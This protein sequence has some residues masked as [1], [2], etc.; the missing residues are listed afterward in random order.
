MNQ[1]IILIIQLLLLL[2][3]GGVIAHA[4]REIAGPGGEEPADRIDLDF[5]ILKG[6]EM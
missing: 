4:W 2:F 3:A 1:A 5:E 6:R